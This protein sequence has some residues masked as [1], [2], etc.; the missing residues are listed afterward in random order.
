MN[1]EMKYQHIVNRIN[2]NLRMDDME[3]RYTTLV[4]IVFL[5]ILATAIK[6]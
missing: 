4:I 3:R 1:H 5:A 2:E 6:F